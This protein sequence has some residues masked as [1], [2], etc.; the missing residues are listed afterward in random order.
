VAPFLNILRARSSQ[1]LLKQVPSS[2]QTGEAVSGCLVSSVMH[3]ADRQQHQRL[4][5]LRVKVACDVY[6][7]DVHP[8]QKT[9]SYIYV[10]VIRKY[11][12]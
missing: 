8:R 5:F 6:C 12:C 4:T 7:W 1:V 9:Y 11:D 2:V 3:D 10:Q